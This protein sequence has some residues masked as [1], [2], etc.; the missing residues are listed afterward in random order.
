[1][2]FVIYF[3]RWISSKWGKLV[4]ADTTDNKTGKNEGKLVGGQIVKYGSKKY[5]ERGK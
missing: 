3:S 2:G 1:M 5:S 4:G